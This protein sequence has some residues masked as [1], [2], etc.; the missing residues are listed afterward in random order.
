MQPQPKENR[1][2]FSAENCIEKVFRLF[3]EFAD[4]NLIFNEERLRISFKSALIYAQ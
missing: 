3:L 2:T 1:L 4:C